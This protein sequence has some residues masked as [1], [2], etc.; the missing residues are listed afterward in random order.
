VIIIQESQTKKEEGPIKKEESPTKKE[1]SP[2]KKE[3]RRVQ[4]KDTRG[5]NAE[6]VELKER[7]GLDYQAALVVKVALEV[8][9]LSRPKPLKVFGSYVKYDC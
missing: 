5:R 9:R 4:I 1:E 6:Q 7:V 3:E 2:T 8:K